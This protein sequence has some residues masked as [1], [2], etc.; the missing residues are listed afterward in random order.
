M[1]D[2]IPDRQLVE[3]RV[4]LPKDL[5]EW[6]ERIARARGENIDNVLTWTLGMLRNFYDRWFYT[7][8]NI[9]Y[10]QSRL[11]TKRLYS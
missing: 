9:S 2:E 7:I 5:V 6:L 11:K 3:V 4:K 10:T 1:I 8:S